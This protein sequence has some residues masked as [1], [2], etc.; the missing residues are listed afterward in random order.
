[1]TDTE[2]ERKMDNKDGKEIYG[3]TSG[4]MCGYVV[5]WRLKPEHAGIEEVTG[6]DGPKAEWKTWPIDYKIE[7]WETKR[8]DTNGDRHQ[9]VTPVMDEHDKWIATF[10]ATGLGVARAIAACLATSAD[11]GI[12]SRV[13]WRIACLDIT[14]SHELVFSGRY[15][16]L[17]DGRF[18]GEP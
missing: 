14:Y 8:K 18:K 5:Q 12:R 10:G 11:L 17:E 2:R 7:G 3:K 6:C 16:K 13:E 9:L 15:E 4:N 1:M